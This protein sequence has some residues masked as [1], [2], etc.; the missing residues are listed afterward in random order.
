[1]HRRG[2]ATWPWAMARSWAAA[3]S[4]APPR[5][6]RV[7]IAYY[8]L[9]GREGRGFA[10]RTASALVE[11]ARRADPTVEVFAKTE[12]RANA[13]TAILNRLGFEMIGE[14]EDHEIGVAWA[15]LLR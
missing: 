12:P 6:G 4:S 13:S 9:P 14:T 8:T 11:I 7:E 15:W 10:G 2:S 5:D 1:M 3:H